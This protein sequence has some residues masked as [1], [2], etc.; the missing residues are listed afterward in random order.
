V[1]T[2]GAEGQGHPKKYPPQ[3]KDISTKPFPYSP[4]PCSRSTILL[5]LSFYVMTHSIQDSKTVI[6]IRET[7]RQT[8]LIF[9]QEQPTPEK[10]KQVYRNTLA[11]FAVKHC[12]DI[13]DI[14]TVLEDSDSWN[15]F[16]RLAADLADLQVGTLGRLEC[17][18]VERNAESC[19]VPS[20]TWEDRMGYVMVQV[21]PPYQEAAILGFVSQ[22][23]E[24]NVAIAQ[25]QP[26]PNLFMHLETVQTLEAQKSEVQ[27]V[28]GQEVQEPS[29]PLV[30]LRNW[31]TRATS[32][33]SSKVL[34]PSG[35]GDRAWQT[36][37][38][39]LA[40]SSEPAFAFR[41][42]AQRALVRGIRL[43]TPTHIR[44]SIEQLYATQ[45]SY[46]PAETVW[47]AP[48]P[49]PT[50]ALTALIQ[51]TQDEELRWKAAEALWMLDP[52]NPA[53]GMRQVM[54]LGMHLG[55]AAIALMVA[56]LQT[57]DRDLSVLIRAYPINGGY[58][59]PDFQLTVFSADHSPLLAVQSRSQDNY[60]ELKLNGTFGEQFSLQV[61]SNQDQLTEYFVI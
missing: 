26:L 44:Q 59:P 27:E 41:L 53:T 11:V 57:S 35:L 28:Q 14:P 20:E 48:D 40:E 61:A 1:Y 58:L 6:P 21:D 55:G 34:N 36:L 31:L 51:L 54:D 3:P 32:D 24:L 47:S 12:L 25:L 42:A 16:S 52:S 37:E 10:A 30:H 15:P 60:I 4:I 33:L 38:N 13:L 5:S 7:D 46:A 9:A 45:R 17:R 23:D 8:A 22:V 18:P 29:T 39:L 50:T 43:D 2:A 19:Y 49:D 56:V